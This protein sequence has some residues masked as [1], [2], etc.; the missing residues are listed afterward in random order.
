MS[1]EFVED[2]VGAEQEHAAVP[3]KSPFLEIGARNV[4]RRLLDEL[5]Y[6]V[7]AFGVRV[8][9]PD[10]DVTITG[11]GAFRNDAEGHE[12]SRHRRRNRSFD[13]RAEPLLVS[14]H[15]IRGKDEQQIVTA[16]LAHPACRQANCRGRVAGLRLEDDR[17]RGKIAPFELVPDE[18]AMLFITD[19]DR[20]RKAR[21]G[22]AQGGDLKHRQVRCNRQQ[23]LGKSKPRDRP[24]PRSGPAGQDHRANEL[25]V[26]RIRS[27]RSR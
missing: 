10:L 16:I 3:K 5:G 8:F 14:D 21:A 22:G 7:N 1:R 15:M 2:D 25:G 13:G 24:Q 26:R 27:S 11:V 6:A 18:K 23:L 9:V 4:E 12:A 19:D 17:A 20:R